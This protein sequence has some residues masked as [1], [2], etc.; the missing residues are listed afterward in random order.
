VQARAAQDAGFESCWVTE[1][2]HSAFV[3][4]TAAIMATTTIVVGTGIALAFPRSPTISAM[5]A[6]DLS[7]LS[8][9]RFI[10]GLG[11]Q[12]KRINELR[13]S[14]P[15]SH[16]A[17]RLAEYAQAMRTVWAANRGEQVVH[18]GR[19][20]TIT[21][22]TFPGYERSH[23]SDV[24]IY[25]AAVGATMAQWCG[26]VADGLL[27]HPLASPDYIRE[28]VTPA[29][30]AGAQ[31]AGRGPRAC[32]ITACPL[33]TVDDNDPERARVETKRQIAFWATTRSYRPI[34]ELHGREHLVPELREA[35]GAGDQRRMVE[36]IDDDL[37]DAIAVSG[38][39]PAV[40][41]Q[42]KRWEGVADRVVLGGPSYGVSGERMREHDCAL[43]GALAPSLN[44][45]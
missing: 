6:A 23:V 4:A 7:E 10:V 25:F 5:S 17:P 19:F 34:L 27:A 32:N 12:V 33:V 26:S 2:S 14:V 45:A 29:V 41:Q 1:T 31:S 40:R 39:S 16:P 38:R 42:L 8:G 15:F 22:P 36:L 28:I 9:E 35:F 44:R 3:A 20:Y 37:C 21:M 18:E 11:S 30:V 43:F 13:F 24:P